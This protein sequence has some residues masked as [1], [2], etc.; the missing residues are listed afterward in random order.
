MKLASIARFLRRS[1]RDAESA[2]DLQFFLDTETEDNLARGMPPEEARAAA[3]RKLGNPTLLREEIYHMHSLG[4]LETTWQDLRYG[5]RTLRESP[6]FTLT[7]VLTLALGIGANTAM[8]SVVRAV[9]LTPLQYHDPDRLVH[10]SI[11]NVRR[12]QQ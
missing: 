10:L 3:R 8:F 1:K 6:S 12:N 9:L 7:A 11:E 4:V 2:S 5:W